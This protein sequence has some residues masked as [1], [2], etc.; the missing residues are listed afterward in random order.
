M[1]SV[2]CTRRALGALVLAGVAATGPLAA[3]RRLSVTRLGDAR[4]FGPGI[5]LATIPEVRFELTRPAHIIVLRVDPAGGIEPVFP[6]DSGA[7][8]ERAPGV[9]VMAAPAPEP[10]SSTAHLAD[11]VV[12]S[13]D[14]L[15]RGGRRVRPP[16]AG[17]DDFEATVVAYWLVIVGDTTTT[18]A[19]VRSLLKASGLTFG[20]L[21]EQLRA[22]P[23]ILMGGRARQW[24]AWYAPVS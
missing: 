13:P 2:R 23:K 19:E 20:S 7:F 5:V 17:S 18:A 24:G 12:R 21:Q 1:I 8:T 11:P 22:L 16:A 9:H 3:Q 14:A 6:T 15:A 4:R 10:P